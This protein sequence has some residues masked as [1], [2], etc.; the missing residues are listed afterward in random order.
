MPRDEFSAKTKGAA[1]LRA[2]GACEKCGTKLRHGE[3]EYHHRLEC[4]LGGT[5]ELSNCQV[6][7]K[8]CH[9][10]TTNRFLK[11]KAK[12]LKAFRSRAN[13]KARRGPKLPLGRDSPLKRKI[14]GEIVPRRP[15]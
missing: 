10:T 9:R 15:R 5:N 8:A 6:R 4:H 2:G 14:S 7:C 13:A 3:A 1:F 12:M 11:E